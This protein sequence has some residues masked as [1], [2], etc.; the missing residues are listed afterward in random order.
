VAFDALRAGDIDA[1]VDY[2][3]TIWATIMK[4]TGVP[5]DRSA[6]LGEV[7]RYLQEE[8]GIVLVCAL[9]FENAYALAMRG[10]RARELG[11]ASLSDLALH[12]PSLE[13]A[14]DYEFFSRAEWA[15]LERVYAF[16]FRAQRSMDPSL[17]Y[18]AVAESQVDVISAFTTDGRIAAFNLAI[19]E[20]DRHAIPPYDAIVLAGARLAR[21]RPEILAAIRSLAG[22]I[23]AEEMRRMNSAVDLEGRSPGDVAREF[24]ERLPKYPR[25]DS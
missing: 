18:P 13:I 6:V 21:E 17:M 19:L 7:G 2:S 11:V 5:P 12:S 24:L 8:H 4:R 1:Y 23:Q 3:G 14:G 25:A 16:A 10:D 20:D 15:S 22:S 9:G